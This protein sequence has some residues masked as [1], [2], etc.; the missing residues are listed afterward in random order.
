MKGK[1]QLATRRMLFSP[2]KFHGRQH[3]ALHDLAA[4][5]SHLQKRTTCWCCTAEQKTTNFYGLLQGGELKPGTA[6]LLQQLLTYF[7]PPCRRSTLFLFSFSL[8]KTSTSIWP[9]LHYL[10]P[11]YLLQTVF[12]FFGLMQTSTGIWPRL[13]QRR[14]DAA[15]DSALKFDGYLMCCQWA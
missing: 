7:Q 9:T 10:Q 15:Q 2:I 5:H 8:T 11:P 1:A 3:D 12:L 4:S 13:Q 6:L 14:T